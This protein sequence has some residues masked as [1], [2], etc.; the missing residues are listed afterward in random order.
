MTP[1]LTVIAASIR[2]IGSASLDEGDAYFN[3]VILLIHADGANG[4]TAASDFSYLNQAITFYGNARL[5]TAAP[6]FGTAAIAMN[7]VVDDHMRIV[8]DATQAFGTGDFSIEFWVNLSVL[9][10]EGGA[11]TDYILIDQNG[12]GVAV[13]VKANGQIIVAHQNVAWL[14]RDTSSAYIA[15]GAYYHIAVCRSGGTLRLYLNGVK[16]NEIS[17]ST[18]F[19]NS[20]TYTLIGAYKETNGT[21]S[22]NLNGYID[23][24]RITKGVA[25]YTSDFIPS[26]AAFP[27]TNQ[28][29]SLYPNV[30]LLLHMDGVN[31]ATTFTD[32][33]LN[34]K[35][36]TAFGNAKIS[37]TQSKFGGASAFFDGTDDYL[38][39]PYSADLNISSGDFTIEAWL[40][41]TSLTVNSGLFFIGDPSSNDNRIQVDYKF[42][43]SVAFFIQGEGGVNDPNCFTAT[44]VI[45]V[46]NWYHI[47]AVQSGSNMLLFVNGV[48]LAFATRTVSVNLTSENT[49][50]GLARNGGIQR[51]CTGYIDDVRVT[52][53][54]ARYT[55]NFTPP[56]TAFYSDPLWSSRS[57]LLEFNGVNG[58]TTGNA[59][60]PNVATTFFGGAK[61]SSLQTRAGRKTSLNLPNAGSYTSVPSSVGYDFGSGDFTI[62]LWF[63]AESS[64]LSRGLICR[65]AALSNYA[66]F[67]LYLTGN[68]IGWS[69]STSGSAWLLDEPN[70]AAITINQWVHAAM[71]R[72][73]NVLKLYVNGALIKTSTISGS[74]MGNSQPV[75][76]GALSAAGEATLIGFIDSVRVTKGAAVYTNNFTPEVAWPRG[77]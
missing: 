56:K 43:G 15:A 54:V 70:I 49:Y 8:H 63:Y 68:N 55:S 19:T 9:P 47:A 59:V 34:V 12:G 10:S 31:N 7:G 13:G 48:L 40:Y 74:L 11:T 5:S 53:G 42:D 45:A 57:L 65:R 1:R 72:S 50:V 16:K 64:I 62:E 2:K 60:T 30:A 20:E 24:I 77:A 69:L 37:T 35:T 61:K 51:F 76:I 28:T 6:K 39:I 58:E 73:G 75:T 26:N 52:K 67:C 22:R 17:N 18:D 21:Y 29:N 46:N 3:N 32:S 33:S 36:V 66:P 14:I 44:G 41:A 38:S 23:E 25:R 71:V 27:N 4:Q